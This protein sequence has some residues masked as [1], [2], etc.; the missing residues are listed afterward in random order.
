MACYDGI[1]G[2]RHCAGPGGRRL[3]GNAPVRRIDAHD[4]RGRRCKFGH[5]GSGLASREAT[6][7]NCRRRRWPGLRRV[8]RAMARVGGR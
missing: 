7:S 5:S 1:G 8:D 4:S 2:Y 6:R 3:G